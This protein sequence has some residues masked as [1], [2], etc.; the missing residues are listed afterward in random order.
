[1][2]EFLA[3][4]AANTATV[5]EALVILT[6]CIG[7]LDAVAGAVRY[8]MHPR[9]GADIRRG[10]WLGFARWL[11]LSLEFAL[12]ADLIRTAIAPTWT[13][14]GQLAAIATIRTVLG[15]FLEKDIDT[16]SKPAEQA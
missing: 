11:V 4:I 7:A 2:E 12:G 14:I 8:L 6:V 1:M 9:D 15:F 16:F 10:I 13:D 5:L 3:P